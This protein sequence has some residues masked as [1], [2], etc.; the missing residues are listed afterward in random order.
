MKSQ[1]NELEIVG[2][3]VLKNSRLFLVYFI[4][5]KMDV[6]LLNSDLFF[7]CF[8]DIVLFILLSIFT[9]VLIISMEVTI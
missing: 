4:F 9:N 1:R 2:L 8:V 7:I 6:F 5:L 3:Y